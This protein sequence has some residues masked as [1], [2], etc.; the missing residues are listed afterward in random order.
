MKTTDANDSGEVDIA[1][2]IYLLAHLFAQGPDP[3]PPFALC[4]RDP[5]EDPLTCD[6]YGPCVMSK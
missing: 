4:S 5:T 6:S 1:D 3:L 2:A